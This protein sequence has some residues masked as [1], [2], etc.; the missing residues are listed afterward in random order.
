[1]K[2]ELDE[3]VKQDVIN[4]SYKYSLSNDDLDQLYQAIE[5]SKVLKDLNLNHNKLTLTD[6][7]L[8][9]AI[10]KNK[11]LKLLSLWNNNVS[12]EGIKH[13]ADALKKNN[14]LQ[15]LY[16]GRNNIGDEGAK[17]I[18]DMLS[19][20]N[21][22]QSIGLS[23]NDITEKGAQSI[24][25][26]LSKGTSL[27]TVDVRHNKIGDKGAQS[28][29]EAFESNHN[30]E[31][32]WLK[33]NNISGDMMNRFKTTLK[34]KIE[35]D[36][37]IN[38]KVHKDV[39]K[40]KSGPETS[41]KKVIKLN[42]NELIKEKVCLEKKG[43]Q[44][45]DL[46]A[47]CKVIV[48]STFLHELSLRGNKLT[49]SNGKLAD[50]IAKNTT[51]KKLSLQNNNIAPEGVKLLADVLKRNN[52]LQILYLTGNNI[53]AEGAKDLA[54]M[55]AVNKSLQE[56]G[57]SNNNIRFE[58]TKL[59]VDA[60]KENDT[61]RSFNLTNNNIG[62][63]G[64]KYVADMLVVNKSLQR[65]DLGYNNIGDQGAESIATSLVVNT[66]LHSIY[67]NNN[68]I[69]DVGAK[70]LVD[71]LEMNHN[72]KQLGL[73]CNKISNDVRDQIKAILAII[74][75]KRKMD[76]AAKLAKQAETNQSKEALLPNKRPRTEDNTSITKDEEIALLRAKL[77]ALEE[78]G[79]SK[80]QSN[81]KD[82]PTKRKIKSL[83]LGYEHTHCSI[84]CHS[85]F[86]TDTDSKDENIRKHL[87]VLSSSKTCDHYFCHGC[88]LRRQ[89][90]I[91]EKNNGRVP[92]W[93]PC[94]VC[95]TKTAFCPS[96]PKYHRLLIDIIKQAN[97][98]DAPQIKEEPAD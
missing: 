1:M 60:L 83:Q 90:A 35:N 62:D 14:T 44:D 25:A 22:L 4:L 59:L 34:R 85:K 18:A 84:T 2:L 64:A 76:R 63:E 55:L 87:P 21:T 70:K 93:I 47:L 92:K 12:D 16:L 37:D 53:G 96:E 79:D 81:T 5:K 54:D 29:A 91:A 46:D 23:I 28:I 19:V 20:N 94:M 6:E 75:K 67:L 41:N 68:T 98:T 51:L 36:K 40:N 97:W 58:G 69:T 80:K 86:S 38:A 56:I 32:I 43:L 8:A 74:K 13:L 49:L 33:D 3:L 9:A 61:F 30:I 95:K 10:A 65:I 89:A 50:A 26:C 78:E 72:I 17:Y 66:G 31:Y 71:A 48:K 88:I 82:T 24:A 57:L 11:T 77:K 39:N 73:P 7:K 45:D 52:T 27:R 15:E 42:L